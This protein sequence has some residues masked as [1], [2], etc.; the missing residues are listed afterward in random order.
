[1]LCVNGFI[2]Y[3]SCFQ[4]DDFKHEYNHYKNVARNA[5]GLGKVSVLRLFGVLS[6]SQGFV[7]QDFLLF[8]G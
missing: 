3:L 1:M 5:A 7:M 4:T 8:T 6:M 2:V